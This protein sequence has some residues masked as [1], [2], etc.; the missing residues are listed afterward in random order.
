[1]GALFSPVAGLAG[2]AFESSTDV[3]TREGLKQSLAPKV[4]QYMEWFNALPVDQQERLRDIGAGADVVATA[5]GMKTGAE[6]LKQTAKATKQAGQSIISG[7]KNVAQKVPGLGEPN[8]AKKIGQETA[9]AVFD[10]KKVLINKPERG[11]G[12]IITK[13]VREKSTKVLAG[14]AV[15]PRGAGMSDKQKVKLVENTEKNVRQLHKLNR[16]GVLK[17]DIGTL[18]DTAQTLVAN[19]DEVGERIGKAVSELKG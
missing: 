14:R 5:F 2:Q 1:M 13:P 9:E 12:E 6:A 16:T 15:S 8:I 17:G 7:A 10:N 18:E 11:I 3:E 19:L 4:G